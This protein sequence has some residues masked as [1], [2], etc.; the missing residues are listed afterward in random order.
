M[1]TENIEEMYKSLSVLHAGK[2]SQ[3]ELSQVGG[4][5]KS[6]TVFG[7]IK[8]KLSLSQNCITVI[9]FLQFF[10]LWPLSSKEFE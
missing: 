7:F 8:S 1:D 3:T 5:E 4:I 9:L 2:Q 6:S 10:G